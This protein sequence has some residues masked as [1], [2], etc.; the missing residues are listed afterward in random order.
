MDF[1]GKERSTVELPAWKM[2]ETSK[3]YALRVLKDNIIHLRL[4]PGSMLSENEL[5]LQ[6][7][8]SRTPVREALQELSKVKL[9]EIYPQRGSAVSLID[10]DLIEEACFMRQVLECATVKLTGER[11]RPEQLQAIGNNV[12]LQEHCLSTNAL[13]R[14]WMLDNEFHHLLFT[15]ARMEQ[16]WQMMTSFTVH[17]DRV[18]NMS[19]TAVKNNHNIA[20]HRAIYEALLSGD[21][22]RAHD[23]LSD[24][25]SRYK[26]DETA[27]RTSYPESYFKQK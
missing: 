11:I 4:P 12:A 22:E 1:I 8:L 27:L 13:E 9:V 2:R 17:F 3:D 24:H 16:T 10:Y 26:V 23:V 19:L 20:D 7:G 15:A 18:R 5:A 14:L 21:T 25:L 6:L